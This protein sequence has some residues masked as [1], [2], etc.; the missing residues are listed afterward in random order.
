MRRVGVVLAVAF[1]WACVDLKKPRAYA[2]GKNDDCVEPWVCLRDGF[3]H[4]PSVGAAVRCAAASECTGAWFCG[5]DGTCRDP[6]AGSALSCDDDSQCARSWRCTTEGVCAEAEGLA[7]LSP[8]PVAGAPVL[9]SPWAKPSR[10]VRTSP[11]ILINTDAGVLSSFT[12]ARLDG[13]AIEVSGFTYGNGLASALP[14]SRFELSAPPD[15]FTL[16]FRTVLVRRG[17]QLSLVDDLGERVIVPPSGAGPSPTHLAPLVWNFDERGVLLPM[18][19]VSFS[20]S[21]DVETWL[22]EGSGSTS[23]MA[24]TVSVAPRFV[25]GG[26]RELALSTFALGR[27]PLVS[28]PLAD[29]GVATVLNREARDRVDVRTDLL[30]RV[31]VHQARGNEQVRL[32]CEDCPTAELVSV[33]ECLTPMRDYGLVDGQPLAVCETSDPEVELLTRGPLSDMRLFGS[34]VSSASNGVSGGHLRQLPLGQLA[35]SADLRAEVFDTLPTAPQ[36]LGVIHTS[37][38]DGGVGPEELHATFS[39]ALFVKRLAERQGAQPGGLTLALGAGAPSFQVAAIVEGLD[40]VLFGSGSVITRQG[41]FVFGVEDEVSRATARVLTLQSGDTVLLVASG[42]TLYSAVSDGSPAVARARLKPA[43]G[44]DIDAFALRPGQVD[45]LEGWAIAN[46]RLLRVT[47]STPERWKTAPVELQSRDPLN[48]W[49][50]SEQEGGAAVVGTTSGEVILLPQRLPLSPALPEEALSLTAACGT[51]LATTSSGVWQLVPSAGGVDWARL[52]TPFS[53]VE[54]KVVRHGA[55][56]F[57]TDLQG[58]VLELP[59]SC[60]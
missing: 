25:R 57:V 23:L 35:W 32:L 24:N 29:G 18:P 46:N 52:D 19:E 17:T 28:A 14:F 27:V 8:T 1:L 36:S 40:A 22:I 38:E 37:L 15:D 47:A 5:K 20:A 4:D 34:R 42:D 53:L 6:D 7:A 56:V 9:H 30:G 58:V 60:P 11:L 26:V 21:S 41:T 54:P 33:A 55:H 44:F 45:F 3:C 49:F 39:G 16:V 10:Q 51:T 2:C 12:A 13:Q 43:P 48:V 31:L 50:L 59:L